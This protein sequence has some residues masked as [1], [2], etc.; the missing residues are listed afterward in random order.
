MDSVV[1]RNLT[2]NS[3]PKSN[4][5]VQVTDA[6]TNSAFLKS[7]NTSASVAEAINQANS[8]I[9][10]TENQIAAT[11][12]QIQ[13]A[14]NL[15]DVATV[16]SLSANLQKLKNTQTSQ[17]LAR[18]LLTTQYGTL[19]SQEQAA[20]LA[21]I[22]KASA[23][24]TSSNTG[25]SLISKAGTKTLLYNASGVQ[26]AY[27]SPKAGFHTE[28]RSHGNTPRVVDYAQG[29]WS[30]SSSRTNKGMIV[31]AQS[32]LKAWN[33]GSNLPSGSS[34]YDPR[35][36]GFQ[37]MYNPGSVS[38]GYNTAPNVDPALYTSG[39]EMFNIAGTSNAQGT[40][41]F[42]VI[43]NRLA[44]LQYY[45][46]LT[47]KVKPGIKDKIYPKPPTDAEETDIYNKGTMYDIEYLLK[48]TMGFTMDSYLRGQKTAD[49]G[50]MSAVPVELHLGNNLRYLGTM[51]ALS[52]NHQI[53]DE[54]MVPLF[55]V[56]QITFSRL[57]DYPAGN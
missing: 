2:S 19:L 13:A 11:Q 49:M 12:N 56:C 8:D 16:T 28:M 30:D 23:S 44:D 14:Q 48:T 6:N 21:A 18:D 4:R 20:S 33:S 34:S 22:A 5:D 17:V 40:V 9:A 25:A 43:I 32:V 37:F 24:I 26:E 39:Q 47:K 10:S 45:D 50:W 31:T 54:R 51:S 1:N 27:F 15:G 46:P 41:T 57:P 35:N 36:Y 53:F 55:T 52:L 29:L 38:M 7:A 3:A 42:E